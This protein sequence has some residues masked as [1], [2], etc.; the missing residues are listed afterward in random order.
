MPPRKK[1]SP[2]KREPQKADSGDESY[3]APTPEEGGA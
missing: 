2:S 1:S 3:R